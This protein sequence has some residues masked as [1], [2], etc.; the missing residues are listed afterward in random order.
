MF[1]D[2]RNEVPLCIPAQGGDTKVRVSGD[3]A[4]RFAVQISEVTAATT[5]HE[6]FFADLVGAFEYDNAPATTPGC[7]RAHE[8]GGATAH[9]DDVEFVHRR[10]TRPSPAA[11]ARNVCRRR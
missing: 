3:E 9:N 5:R 10:T 8:S 6:Y 1:L 2:Q 7:N 11:D 4:C